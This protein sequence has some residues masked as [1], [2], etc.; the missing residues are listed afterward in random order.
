M[1]DLA[2]GALARLRHRMLAWLVVEYRAAA[3]DADDIL[4]GFDRHAGDVGQLSA[5][6]ASPVRQPAELRTGVKEA[7]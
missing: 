7:V 2:D 6:T 4:E 1:A 5:S 3:P